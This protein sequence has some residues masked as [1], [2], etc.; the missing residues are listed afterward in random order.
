MRVALSEVPGSSPR[1]SYEPVD[2]RRHDQWFERQAIGY[3][4]IAGRSNLPR[5]LYSAPLS[6]AFALRAPLLTTVAL[7]GTLVED[8]LERTS[9]ARLIL[10]GRTV[11]G[12]SGRLSN[13]SGSLDELMK[14]S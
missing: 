14:E 12:V 5:F 6:L 3:R 8:S 2:Q 4:P 13:L 11:V 1:P 10:V 9:L 7:G